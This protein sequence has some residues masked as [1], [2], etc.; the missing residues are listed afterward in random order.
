M[1]RRYDPTISQALF[2]A[3]ERMMQSD[4]FASLTI[5]GLVNEVGTT[6]PAFYRRYDSIARLA[7]DVILRRYGDAPP[8]D[9]GA[10]RTDLLTLQRNDLAMMNSSLISRNLPA[11]LEAM[12]TDETIRSMY[13]EQFIS[14]RRNN[15]AKVIASAVDRGEI[16]DDSFDAEYVCD[17]LFGPLLSRAL[18][19]V[20]LPINDLL[21]RRTVDT[22]MREL[23]PRV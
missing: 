10:L 23:S 16:E 22:V 3:A 14:P 20:E 2:Q 6:R 18:L 7:L 9:T 4:G 8:A 21:A 12:R 13:M 11:L 17:L 1:G 5:D 19:P 15:V